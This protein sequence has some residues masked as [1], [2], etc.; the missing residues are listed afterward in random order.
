MSKS[1][2]DIRPNQA[3]APK[4]HAD[5]EGATDYSGHQPNSKFTNQGSTS[6]ETSVT[7]DQR[8]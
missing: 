5:R 8:K 3:K 2:E 6:E 7:K 4:E 1:K